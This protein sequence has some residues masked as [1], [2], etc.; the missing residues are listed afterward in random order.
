MIQLVTTA[1]C[2]EFD[3]YIRKQGHFMQRSAWGLCR[4]DW[5]WQGL[6]EVDGDGRILAA[7][8]L[9]SRPV[10]GMRCRLFYAPR[11]P[12]FDSKNLTALESLLSAV[13]Q[14]VRAQGGYLLRMDPQILENE[15]RLLRLLDSYGF[16]V[17]AIDDFT[18]FQPRFVYQLSLEGRT[19]A[20]LWQAMHH[21]TRY[22]IGL[23]QRRGLRVVEAGPEGCEAFAQLMAQTG[24]RRGFHSRTAAAYADILVHY[25][26]DA[27]LWLALDGAEAVAGLLCI[28]QPGQLWNLYNGSSQVGRQQRANELLQWYAICWARQQG[29]RC[30]DLRGVEGAPVPENPGYGLHRFKGQLGGELVRYAGQMDWV[31]R[32]ISCRMIQLAQRWQKLVPRGLRREVHRWVQWITEIGR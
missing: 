31:C 20:D 16:Q 10:T 29:C 22:N 32:P 25:G 3:A 1:N 5:L 4:P 14:L 8:A 13:Q 6:M 23:A 28:A 7:M 11:G 17:E 26:D 27:H 24:Q 30:Y 2:A 9:L 12:V 18:S 21:K 15:Y 19:E